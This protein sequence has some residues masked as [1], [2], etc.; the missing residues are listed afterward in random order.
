MRICYTNRVDDG[1][2]TAVPDS[3]DFPITNVQYQR[4]TKKYRVPCS[5]A[6]VITTHL[7]V[8]APFTAIAIIGHNF[9]SSVTILAEFAVEDSWPGTVSYAMSYNS[10]MIM[11]FLTLSE[12]SYL[13]TEAGDFLV[14]ESGDYLMSE[15]TW[16]WVRLTITDTTN[17]AGYIEIGRIW[18]GDYITVDPSSLIDFS[19][20]KK[21]SG[22]IVRGRSRQ[23][24]AIPGFTWRKFLLN[25]PVTD[26]DMIQQIE[27]L[28]DYS[29]K[30]RSL[31]FCNFDTIRDYPI[32]EPCYCSIGEDITFRHMDTMR[33]QYSLV[34]EEDLYG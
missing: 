17:P 18:I 8:G 10:G 24:L 26:Y 12:S 28:F 20:V 7:A 13:T 34:L 27:G 16:P 4:L 11:T 3:V 31:I 19:I 21:S 1:T 30:Y 25:F 33:F 14:T 22:T 15:A 5:S 23:K 2:I 6:S 9:T 29:G 32:V